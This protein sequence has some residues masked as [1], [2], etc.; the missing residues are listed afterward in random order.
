MLMI[1]YKTIRKVFVPLLGCFANPKLGLKVSILLNFAGRSEKCWEIEINS[2]NI[3]S[4]QMR[5]VLAHQGW[6][7]TF[8]FSNGSEKILEKS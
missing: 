3:R 4:L 1:L 8:Y 6:E 5:S 2:E 7:K